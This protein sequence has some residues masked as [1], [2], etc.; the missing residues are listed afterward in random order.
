MLLQRAGGLHRPAGSGG[1]TPPTAPRRV[2][3]VSPGGLLC[4]VN[5]CRDGFVL[6]AWLPCQGLDLEAGPAQP[7]CGR[8]FA[9][10]LSSHQSCYP[11]P[12]EGLGGPAD[13][14]N[15]SPGPWSRLPAV[16]ALGVSLAPLLPLS[17]P[18]GSQAASKNAKRR[19]CW[20]FHAPPQRVSLP[21]GVRTQAACAAP[22]SP[23]VGV[24]EHFLRIGMRNRPV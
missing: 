21:F 20:S 14:G 13:G 19:V 6:Q 15:T 2:S 1:R 18:P 8:A 17:P 16:R 4:F 3:A 22:R 12:R 11:G 23:S 10:H 5:S 7:G 24:A 9:A